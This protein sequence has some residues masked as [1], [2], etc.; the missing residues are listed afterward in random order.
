MKLHETRRQCRQPTR[1]CDC[2]R[3]RP[4]NSPW[5]WCLL[6]TCCHYTK[7]LEGCASN[8]PSGR[9]ATGVQL[10]STSNESELPDLEWR[11]DFRPNSRPEE[12]H[13]GGRSTVHDGSVW[14]LS[15]R[16]STGDIS[17]C[18]SMDNDTHAPLRNAGHRKGSPSQA[19]SFEWTLIYQYPCLWFFGMW[20]YNNRK[21]WLVGLGAG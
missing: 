16:R 18:S 12:L 10:M 11:T 20:S 19:D 1:F 3:P 13:S 8:V 17:W 6:G 14:S 15:G 21:L 4:R 9:R 2:R 5:H 7:R